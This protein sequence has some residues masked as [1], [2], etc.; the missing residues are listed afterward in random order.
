[1]KWWMYLL[2]SPIIVYHWLVRRATKA[3]D[4]ALRITTIHVPDDEP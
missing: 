4:M 2:L 1:M 3:K